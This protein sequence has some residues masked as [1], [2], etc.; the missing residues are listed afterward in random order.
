MEKQKEQTE[1]NAS[2]KPSRPKYQEKSKIGI[3]Q[4][5]KINLREKLKDIILLISVPTISWILIVGIWD[6]I[7]YMIIPDTILYLLVCIII[8]MISGF[9]YSLKSKKKTGRKLFNSTLSGWLTLLPYIITFLFVI[10]SS[11]PSDAVKR[12]LDDPILILGF[13]ASMIFGLVGGFIGCKLRDR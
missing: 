8:P 1:R 10:T 12:I 6:T 4:K 11:T 9:I 2:S 5:R 3:K 7:S 13:V